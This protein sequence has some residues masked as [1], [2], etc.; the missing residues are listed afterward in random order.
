[1]LSTNQIETTMVFWILLFLSFVLSVVSFYCYWQI[2]FQRLDYSLDTSFF[3]FWNT[4][5]A[6]QERRRCNENSRLHTL[7][8]F[9][10]S[11]LWG[12]KRKLGLVLF[13]IYT[14]RN[15]IKHVAKM[16][17][18]F[19]LMNQPPPPAIRSSTTRQQLQF[20]LGIGLGVPLATLL[21]ELDESSWYLLAASVVF[22]TV[23]NW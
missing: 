6:P 22:L 15:I 23:S 19:S 8:G 14:I 1:M 10:T 7:D 5:T 13:F 17:K 12:T 3:G 20:H 4:N 21:M 11:V 16:R 18:G 2:H 9:V